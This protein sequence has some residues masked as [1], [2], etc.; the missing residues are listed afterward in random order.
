M[1]WAFV[2]LACVTLLGA[3]LVR[4]LRVNPG[5][6][7]RD[8]L[9]LQVSLPAASYN[10]ERAVSFYSALERALEERLG[11]RSISIVNEIPLAGSIGRSLVSP[12]PGDVGPEAVVREA[13]PAYFEV[14]RIPIV[15]GRSFEPRDNASAPPR[16]VIGQSLIER[17]FPSEEP[18]GRRIWFAAGAQAAEIIGVVG[19]VKHRA[20]DEAFLPA[21][22][23]SVLQAPSRSSIVVVRSARPDADVIAAVRDEVRR[24]DANLPVYRVRSMQDVVAAS[25]GVPAR[26]VL[27][28]TFMGFALLAVVLG[29]IGVFGVVAHDVASRRTELALR[30]ALGADPMRIVTAT[31]GRAAVMVGSGLALGGL[32]SIWAARTDPLIALRSE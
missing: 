26:R 4:L 10:L 16:V 12:R 15:T 1:P 7:A 22:Y 32:L 28:A 13:G 6:D 5:F 19:D 25:P 14:M 11:P 9:A 18:I 29:A 27:T 3:S 8:V 21:V 17:L 24:L 20:L 30:I 31:F 23:R 2:L